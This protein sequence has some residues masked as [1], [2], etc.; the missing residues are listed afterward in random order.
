MTLL[1]NSVRIPV[2][3][4][5]TQKK[6]VMAM[7][8]VLPFIFYQ[9]VYCQE[10]SLPFQM[11]RARLI[12]NRT[13]LPV[14]FARVINKELRSGVL[15]D[16]LGVFS[17]SARIGDTLYISSL[18]YLPTKIGVEDS[19]VYQIRIPQI[20]LVEQAYELSGVDIYGWG[21]Y[22]E[23][24]YKFLHEPNPNEKIAKMQDDIHK[25]LGK[26]PKHPPSENGQ[27]GIPLGSPITALYN[28]FS[29]EGKS[30]RR[31]AAAKE[32]D[33]VFLLTYQKFNR[34]IVGQITGLTGYLLDQFMVF[35]RPGDEFLLIAN[36][37]EIH[38]KVLA[39]FERFKKEVLSQPKNKASL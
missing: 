20:S 33:R 32:R 30:M 19:L 38:K 23:F 31:V 12:N 9:R 17:M 13:G 28:M 18:S 3:I 8:L 22:Q 37:Y 16:S 4:N 15:T 6:L 35:C 14:V 11:I 1:T 5:N 26:L 21:T 25:Y 39:D 2:A 27:M 24:K 7:L 29:K 34:D 10:K 36:D